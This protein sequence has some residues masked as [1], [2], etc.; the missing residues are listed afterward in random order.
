MCC[1]LL[2]RGRCVM[3]AG[4]VLYAFEMLEGMRRALLCVLEAVE[5]G[6]CLLEV[7]WR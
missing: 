6:P 7:F 1:V 4:V 3:Y 5:G 2:V